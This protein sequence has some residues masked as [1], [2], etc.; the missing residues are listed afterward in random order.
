MSV[1][2]RA[3]L[4]VNPWS[5]LYE[6]LQHQTSLS[7]G[8]ISAVVGLLV[9]LGWIPLRQKPT[10]GT[11]ANI[12]V[13]AVASDLGLALIPAVTTLAGQ[14]MLLLLGIALNGF[15]VAVYVGARFGPGPRDGLMTGLSHRTGGSVRLVRTLLEVTVLL[16]GWALGG[17]AGVGTLLYA[18]L[19]GPITQF[20]LPRFAYRGRR[21]AQAAEV[22]TVGAAEKLERAV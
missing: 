1:L 16:V 22:H 12:A 7:F 17:R 15:A 10:L 19:V 11:V 18:L 3:A 5:V 20:F 14:M 13:L 2:V 8:T 21:A 6:G 4:G 9:L